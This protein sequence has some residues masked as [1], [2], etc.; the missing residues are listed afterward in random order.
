TGEAALSLLEAW[1]ARRARAPVERGAFWAMT[2]VLAL[3]F[4]FR[5]TFAVLVFPLWI[6]AAR[7][8]A[9]GRIAAGGAVLAGAAFG[10]TALVAR[11]S[12]GWAAYRATTSGFFSEVVLATK[13]FGGGFGKIP[14]QAT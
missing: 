12:G 6:Y 8:H 4:G 7:R 3:A 1:L 9:W 2:L 11:L 5:S 14:S 13:I 10:W